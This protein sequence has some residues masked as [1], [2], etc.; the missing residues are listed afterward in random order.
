MTKKRFESGEGD[1]GPMIYD[2]TGVDDYYFIND[3]EELE[4]F[5]KLINSIAYEWKEKYDYVLEEYKKQL[6]LNNE[7]D[8]EI[9]RLKK[10]LKELK[11]LI[12][13]FEYEEKRSLEWKGNKIY[14]KDTHTVLKMENDK[15]YISCQV[16]FDDSVEVVDHKFD[17][18]GI[19][20][21]W[22]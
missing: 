15:M 8:L 7:K 11:K 22:R 6:T 3:P 12:N 10:E 4:Q 18:V 9:S 20:H 21:Q 1:K 16:P 17:V 13:D 19:Y 2:N 5:I 14:I